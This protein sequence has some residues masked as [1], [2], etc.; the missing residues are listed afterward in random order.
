MGA[1]VGGDLSLEFGDE[2]VAGVLD[3]FT[4][5]DERDDA[6][7]GGLVGGTDDGGFGDSVMVHQ[8]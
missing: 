7:S 1:D 8:C 6:L 4:E 5:D 3:A 2:D